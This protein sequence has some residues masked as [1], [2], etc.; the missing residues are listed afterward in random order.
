[1][2]VQQNRRHDFV[3]DQV[4]AILHSRAPRQVTAAVHGHAWR[5]LHRQLIISVATY[6]RVAAM[7]PACSAAAP[8]GDGFGAVSPGAGQPR[9][10]ELG[11]VLAAFSSGAW[12]LAEQGVGDRQRAQGFAGSCVSRWIKVGFLAP[13]A[14][15][16]NSFSARFRR[17]WRRPS[18]KHANA[19]SP[20]GAA[21]RSTTPPTGWWVKPASIT[22]SSRP[23]WSISA[24]VDARIGVPNRLTPPRADC[25]QMALAVK[26]DQPL[27]LSPGDGNQRKEFRGAAFACR[28]QTA[29]VLRLSQLRW[30]MT[31]PGQNAN[32][33]FNSPRRQAKPARWAIHFRCGMTQ[34]FRARRGNA[35]ATG[36]D[37]RIGQMMVLLVAGALG[38]GGRRA[39][40]TGARK[41]PRRAA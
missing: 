15:T 12:V 4:R 20:D 38:R 27:P 32:R 16:E 29:R 31:N 35:G 30:G 28:R 33:Q 26:V 14:S 1:M 9:I 13:L 24:G 3:S 18:H 22:C 25:V 6:Q 37:P 19:L 8:A 40:C 23:S 2:P 11:A 5:A 17:S 36:P 39:G 34:V 41:R 10:R 21:S 7:N